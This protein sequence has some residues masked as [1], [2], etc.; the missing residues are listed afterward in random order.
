LESSEESPNRICPQIWAKGKEPD[1]ELTACPAEAGGVVILKQSLGS[2]FLILLLAG[3]LTG[4]A[5]AMN[6]PQAWIVLGLWA[7]FIAISLVFLDPS[8][9]RERSRVLPGVRRWDV[10]LATFGA[11]WLYPGTLALAG[12]DHRFAWSPSWGGGVES[13]ALSMFVLGYGISFWAMKANRFYA[14]FVRIQRERGHTIV[15]SG[16]YRIVRHPGYAGM[17]L[18]HLALPLGLGSIYACAPALLGAGAFVVR[19]AREDQL[20]RNELPGYLDYTLR[21][22]WRLLPGLW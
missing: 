22:R 11:F 4:C 2:G 1:H 20:L 7:I 18:S 15:T 21:V 9:L 14:A 8:L 12:L 13:A 3:V 5:G 10:A 16:P 6:W 17:V 19:T